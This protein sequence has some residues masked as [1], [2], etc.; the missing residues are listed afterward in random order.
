[1]YKCTNDTKT[2]NVFKAKSL[3]ENHKR[4]SFRTELSYI[5]EQRA[6]IQTPEQQ[7]SIRIVTSKHISEQAASATD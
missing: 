3:L 1:M 7:A 4:I 2:G 5:T 6:P